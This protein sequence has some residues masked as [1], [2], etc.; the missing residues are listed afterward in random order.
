ME[1]MVMQKSVSVAAAPAAVL[2]H[3][4]QGE[5]NPHTGLVLLCPVVED[6]DCVA[7]CMQPARV[8]LSIKV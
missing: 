3:L 6:L 4:K 5:L 1:H 7:V 8:T 2:D